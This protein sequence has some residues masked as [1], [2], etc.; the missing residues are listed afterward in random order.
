MPSHPCTFP[1]CSLAFTKRN[2]LRQHLLTAHAVTTSIPCPHPPCTLSFLTR[3]LLTKHVHLAH[4]P[5]RYHCGLCSLSFPRHLEYR[6]H[7]RSHEGDDWQCGQCGK[8][9]RRK[10]KREHERSHTQEE[11]TC[12]ME[13]CGWRGRTR[14]SLRTHQRV[15]HGEG[16]EGGRRWA[17]EEC[18]KRFGYKAVM[19]KHVLRVHRARSEE[20]EERA[21]KRR[22]KTEKERAFGGPALGLEMAETMDGGAEEQEDEEEEETVTQR[23]DQLEGFL[24]TVSVM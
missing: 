8:T 6:R 5:A 1:S 23:F 2:A 18:G 4:T 24:T 15:K 13:G 10:R 17:C 14:G 11:V 9:V 12:E 19:E 3:S 16:K 22:R 20:D 21:A 7:Q